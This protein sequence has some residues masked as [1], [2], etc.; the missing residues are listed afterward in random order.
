MSARAAPFLRQ[1]PRNVC[2]SFA[3]GASFT[4]CVVA[5]A[6]ARATYSIV[7][8][9]PATG[10]VGGAGTSCLG[11]SDVY[12][13]Y[14]SVPGVGAVHAQALF[15]QNARN[16]AVQLL[17]QGQSPAQVVAAI[18]AQGF[19]GNAA[20]RQYGVVDVTGRSAGFTGASAQSFADDVQGSVS[21]FVYSIQGNI[22]SSSAV[23]TQASSAFEAPACDLAARLLS[24]LE[25]GGANGE[26]DS[27]CTGDGIPSD[28]A[29]LQVDLPDAPRGSF[30]SLRVPTSGEDDPLPLLRAQFEAWRATS[31]CPAAVLDAGTPR[32]SGAS[33]GEGEPRL[34][35]AVATPPP[36]ESS[37]P[38]VDAATAPVVT[39][40]LAGEPTADVAAPAR[41]RADGCTLS[42]GSSRL[43]PERGAGGPRVPETGLAALALGAVL[44]Q[45]ARR[46]RGSS[47]G[48]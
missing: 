2:R 45:R 21:G 43:V 18:T 24:A 30:L 29:F 32:D 11:G 26:G 14:G 34:D 37:A 42:V 33:S 1:R 23:L 28:S 8:A 20:S 10:Q 9:D 38:A 19:D 3:F 13:I 44:A 12:V 31:P 36:P 25:A 7:A 5:S 48:T 40:P 39:P 17:G 47:G 35:A 4:C 22:L 41:S 27:R 16:A 6:P 46:R 15:N